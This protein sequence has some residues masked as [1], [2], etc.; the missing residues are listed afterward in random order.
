MKNPVEL[1]KMLRYSKIYPAE[2]TSSPYHIEVHEVALQYLFVLADNHRDFTEE[3]TILKTE[4]KCI[5]SS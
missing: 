5:I 1:L 3:R 2:N 4:E